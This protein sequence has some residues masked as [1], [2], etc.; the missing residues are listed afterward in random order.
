MERKKA[1]TKLILKKKILFKMPHSKVKKMK[2]FQNVQ[3]NLSFIG[4][5]ANKHPLNNR[6]IFYG[7]TNILNTVAHFLYLFYIAD[8]KEKVMKSLYISAA[9]FIIFISF[10]S[11]VQKMKTIFSLINKVENLINKSKLNEHSN[12]ILLIIVR[13]FY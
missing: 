5:S 8:T 2:I 4:F 9:S 7:L 11:T 1:E 10:L 13:L 3:K 12:R 6:L